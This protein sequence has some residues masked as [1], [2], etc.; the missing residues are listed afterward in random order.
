MNNI[1]KIEQLI[2]LCLVPKL[3]KNYDEC[4]NHN[5]FGIRNKNLDKNFCFLLKQ[6]EAVNFKTC[7]K[8]ESV[9]S[10]L[11]ILYYELS[12]NTSWNDANCL[13]CSEKLNY[14]FQTFYEISLTNVLFEKTDFDHQ[15]IFDKCL[16][17]LHKKL[18]PAEFKKYPAQIA[19]Y[20]TLIKDLKV[21]Q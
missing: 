6:L 4:Q 9:I 2:D 11:L 12:D 15:E 18:S 14:Y 1:G 17:N 10:Q 3:N 21:S 7:N 13:K 8:P 5:E 16:E 20:L 19:V